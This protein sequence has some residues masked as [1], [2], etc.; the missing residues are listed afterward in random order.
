MRPKR[1]L[2]DRAAWNTPQHAFRKKVKAIRERG[3]VRGIKGEADTGEPGS[4]AT[5]KDEASREV[6]GTSA[7]GRRVGSGRKA[8]ERKAEHSMSHGPNLCNC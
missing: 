7:A 2:K 4:K 5:S 8:Q 6:R 3:V 1:G